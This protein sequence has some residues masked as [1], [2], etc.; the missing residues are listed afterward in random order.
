VDIVREV[1]ERHTLPRR[2]AAKLERAGRTEWPD[3]FEKALAASTALALENV[4][5]LW[6]WLRVQTFELLESVWRDVER[7][8]EALLEHETLSKKQLRELLAGTS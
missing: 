4:W 7:V 5:T 2:E 3:D 1:L 8:A 6:P